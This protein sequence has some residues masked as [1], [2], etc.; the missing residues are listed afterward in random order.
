MSFWCIG[1]KVF[2][3]GCLNSLHLRFS[4]RSLSVIRSPWLAAGDELDL[5]CLFPR[6]RTRCRLADPKVHVNSS[7][8]SSRLCKENL[9]DHSIVVVAV[10][11]NLAGFCMVESAPNQAHCAIVPYWFFSL[12]LPQPWAQQLWV[13][14]ELHRPWPQRMSGCPA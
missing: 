5:H 2:A 8:C 4:E 13:C 7:A 11:D 3:R 6:R 14:W 10:F 12:A 1:S 9:L